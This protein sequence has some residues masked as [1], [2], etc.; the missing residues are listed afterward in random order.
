MGR[1]L[2]PRLALAPSRFVDSDHPAVRDFTESV[3]GGVQDP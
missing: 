3:V 2:D 1:E